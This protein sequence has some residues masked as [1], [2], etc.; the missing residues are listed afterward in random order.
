MEF[1]RVS[2]RRAGNPWLSFWKD[3]KPWILGTGFLL[4]KSAL[5]P[6][7]LLIVG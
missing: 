5:P 7:E 1:F 3:L 6:L 2:L 4:I